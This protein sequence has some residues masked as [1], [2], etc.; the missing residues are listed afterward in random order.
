MSNCT[1]FTK[2]LFCFSLI[3]LLAA[4]C[5][6]PK[7]YVFKTIKH[8]PVEKNEKLKE[9]SPAADQENIAS[10]APEELEVEATA[11][12]STEKAAEALNLQKISKQITE[13]TTTSRGKKPSK[14]QQ[15]KTAIQV[16]KEIKKIRKSLDAQ[17]EMDPE[18]TIQDEP[19]S[20]FVALLLAILVGAFGIH[21]F[22]LGYTAI[23]I[24][25]LLTLGGCGVWALI[26]LIR[27]A[28]GD[29]GPADGS[30]YEDTL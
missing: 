21:R 22:Y 12:V 7:Y 18:Q 5:S 11:L 19:K 14:L 1:P 29:L 4:A 6:S 10:I 25:Q 3:L 28:M 9:Q 30:P 2:L 20:Q 27:I 13:K 24:I 8:S 17:A 16:K 26:D 23:G 15:I